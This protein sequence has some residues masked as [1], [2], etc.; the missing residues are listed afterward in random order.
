MLSPMSAW[1][2]SRPPCSVSHRA[3]LPHLRALVQPKNTEVMRGIPGSCFRVGEEPASPYEIRE[4]RETVTRCAQETRQT[5]YAG[6]FF[7]LR[8]GLGGDEPAGRHVPWVQPLLD[9]RVDAAGGHRAEIQGGRAEP[10]DVSDL[11][12]HP[13]DRGRL[14]QLDPFDVVEARGHQALGQRLVGGLEQ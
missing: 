12:E 11:M 3:V 1:T 13:R 4:V 9:V 7:E 8:A 5:A 14:R 6:V 2:S 10:P